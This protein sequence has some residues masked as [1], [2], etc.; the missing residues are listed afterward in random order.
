M[1]KSLSRFYFIGFSLR[2]AHEGSSQVLFDQAVL[3]GED[4]EDLV[5]RGFGATLEESGLD[6]LKNGTGEDLQGA[7]GEAEMVG[8][9]GDGSACTVV[10]YL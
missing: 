3:Q 4:T 7:L 1:V 6:G 10:H 8:F 2:E 9:G 5:Q